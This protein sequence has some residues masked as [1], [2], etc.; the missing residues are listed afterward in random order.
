LIKECNLLGKAIGQGDVI[1]I[2]TSD[3]PAMT[4]GKTKIEAFGETLIWRLNYADAPILSCKG[5]Q[6][7]PAS[8]R[9]TVVD[10]NEFKIRKGLTQN[11]FDGLPEIS[12]TIVNSH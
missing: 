3:V 7:L 1:C 12:I 11:T 2:H 9:R 6:N 8:I 10:D 4:L 5:R